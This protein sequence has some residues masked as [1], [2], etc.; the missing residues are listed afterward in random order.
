MHPGAWAMSLAASFRSGPDRFIAALALVSKALARLL[1]PPAWRFAASLLHVSASGSQYGNNNL[2]DSSNMCHESTSVALPQTIGVPV[3]TVKIEDFE[4]TD[5]VM[6]F[7]QNVGVNSPRMLHQLQEVRERGVPIITFNPLRERGLESFTNPQS[8]IEM[9]TLSETKISTQYH[10]L[11]PGSDLAV[12]VGMSKALL[13][14]DDEAKVAG[15]GRV[16]DV[17]FI[18][19][20]TSGFDAFV[21]SM[22]HFQWPEIEA[23]S[24]LS[25]AAIESA[26]RVYGN[27]DAVIICYARGRHFSGARPFECPGPAHSRDHGKARARSARSPR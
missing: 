25:R 20:D 9:L 10:Q 17:D 21:A 1:T 15:T 11:Q 19:Q 16:I 8:P 23:C 12:L 22:N 14:M 4:H 24:G 18:E 7:G 13:A 5:C 26:A 27:A 2:P 6:F 3:G